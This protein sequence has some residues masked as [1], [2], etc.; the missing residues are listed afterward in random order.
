MNLK[1]N[2]YLDIAKKII[3]DAP[4][5]YNGNDEAS[6]LVAQRMIPQAIQA[7]VIKERSK[8]QKLLAAFKFALHKM[9]IP[10]DNGFLWNA[11][12]EY[13]ET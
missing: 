13:E 7:E 11:I 5:Y 2:P 4:I 9:G 8:S 1:L 3:E 6:L 12:K 10:E